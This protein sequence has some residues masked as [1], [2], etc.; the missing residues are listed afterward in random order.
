MARRITSLMTASIWVA[1][2]ACMSS[3]ESMSE[4]NKTKAENGEPWPEFT[5]PD[6][7]NTVEWAYRR[8]CVAVRID[9]ATLAR[10]EMN[11]DYQRS[12]TIHLGGGAADWL[13]LRR[14][15]LYDPKRPQVGRVVASSATGMTQ[16]CRDPLD[17]RI[18]ADISSKS[19]EHYRIVAR[20]FQGD[21]SIS[22]TI[23]R[24]NYDEWPPVTDDTRAPGLAG[25]VRQEL[26][27]LAAE[28]LD[29]V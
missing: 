4:G 28:F 23:E 29:Q 10:G 20:L 7:P 12:Y 25:V 11:L 19:R 26:E 24:R 16:T 18:L 3:A 22:R 2:A 9:P 8:V 17:I 13:S 15:S 6:R 21:R 1:L 5:S 27:R 14:H